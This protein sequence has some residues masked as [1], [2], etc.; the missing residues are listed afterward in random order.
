MQNQ[1]TNQAFWS[2]DVILLDKLGTRLKLKR[3]PVFIIGDKSSKQEAYVGLWT[4]CWGEGARGLSHQSVNSNNTRHP[5]GT[6]PVPLVL[7][8]AAPWCHQAAPRSRETHLTKC[9]K[10]KKKKPKSISWILHFFSLQFYTGICWS[11]RG[12]KDISEA[13]KA[14]M[15]KL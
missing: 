2:L 13:S 5:P 3:N 15:W 14:L 6:K 4:T 8:G 10:E 7:T 11:N 1:I 12:G 9:H